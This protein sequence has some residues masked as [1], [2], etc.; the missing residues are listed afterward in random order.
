[1]TNDDQF[2]E[3]N[4]FERC[5]MSVYLCIVFT[6]LSLIIILFCCMYINVSCKKGHFLFSC[7]IH[8]LLYLPSDGMLKVVMRK[9]MSSLIFI[10][11][12]HCFSEF[13][14]IPAAFRHCNQGFTALGV[15]L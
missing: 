1:M 14:P 11:M 13:Y 3:I 7:L 6:L 9:T 4:M 10:K 8:F 12:T 2:I 15:L 5:N